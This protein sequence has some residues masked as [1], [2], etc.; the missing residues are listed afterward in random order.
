MPKKPG[1]IPEFMRAEH[2]GIA[3]IQ[4][5]NIMAIPTPLKFFLISHLLL[6]QIE[7]FIVSLVIILA[8][9]FS[10]MFL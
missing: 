10:S 6:E 3:R 1:P 8:I 4:P 7:H 5:N 9:V 2:V